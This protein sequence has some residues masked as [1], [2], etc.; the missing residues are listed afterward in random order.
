[1]LT[2][3][4]G[5]WVATICA[6]YIPTFGLDNIDVITTFPT[7]L[8]KTAAQNDNAG[9]FGLIL[10]AISQMGED[11]ETSPGA[12]IEALA[13]DKQSQRV[14]RQSTPNYLFQNTSQLNE[15]LAH[16]LFYQ[17]P[18]QYNYRPYKLNNIK[19]LLLTV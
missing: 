14:V 5:I 17:L 4:N 13:F 8:T 9:R 12:T 15:A 11:L 3:F 7:D 2:P 16:Q 19:I 10:S 18:H 6:V 1:M